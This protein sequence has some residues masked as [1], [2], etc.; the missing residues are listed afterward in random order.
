MEKDF[1][2][3]FKLSYLAIKIFLLKLTQAQDF[4][5]F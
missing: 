2:F 1:L 5:Q 4:I 3:S